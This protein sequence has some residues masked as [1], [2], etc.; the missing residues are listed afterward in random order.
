MEVIVSILVFFFVLL[1]PLVVIGAAAAT[2][3]RGA[4]DLDLRLVYFVIVAFFANLIAFILS[5]VLVTQI[6]SLF[7]SVQNVSQVTDTAAFFVVAL[8][9]GIW[10][11]RKAWQY[12]SLKNTFGI[13]RVYL[14]VWMVIALLAAVIAGGMF[15]SNLFKVFAGLVRPGN[16]DGAFRDT[17]AAL[18][19]LLIASAV[20]FYHR[21]AVE[22]LPT[23]G[24]GREAT[25][26]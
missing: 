11:L 20:W 21:T 17:L 25:P 3:R 19:N 18:V 23:N 6:A 9:V 8:P 14:Y 4:G 5:L 24:S 10:H 22:G 7:T 16:L 15:A 26:A 13:L 1:V 12:A 2:L